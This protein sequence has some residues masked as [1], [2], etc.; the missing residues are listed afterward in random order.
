MKYIFL[1]LLLISTTTINIGQSLKDGK[2]LLNENGDHYLKLSFVS[3]FWLRSGKY[4]PGSTVFG[5]AK[6]RGTDIGIRRFRLQL[7]GQLTDKIFFFSQFGENNYNNISD[8]K[9]SFFVHDVYSE[10]AFD[11]T[12]LSVGVGLSGWSGLARFASP[13][14]GSIMGLD[15]PLFQQ[16]TNDVTDQFLRKLGVFAKGKLGRL[17]YRILVAQPL[18]FQKSPNY[19]AEV[20]KN[21]NFSSKPPKAQW[22]G[23]F[24]YQFKDIEANTTP[25]M[26]GTYHGKK[27][28]FNIGAGI[29]FQKNSMWHLSD[30][31]KDTIQT[32]LL[33]YAVD[34]F[35][36]VPI[37]IKGEALSIYANA[38]HLDYGP[39]YIRN[40]GV[41]NP[42]NGS[43]NTNVINGGGLAFPAYGTGN[44]LYF[45]IGY[46]CKDNLIGKSTLM[47]YFSLENASYAR[48]SKDMRYFST[49]VNVLLNGHKSK[50]TIAYENRPIFLDNSN[51]VVRIGNAA[52]QYQ[53]SF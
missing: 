35:Y 40:L 51:N 37:G 31:G 11:K 49:G 25:Y 33:M 15:A 21:S 14:V 10:Y 27:S 45:Q 32:N 30:S 19:S 42:T 24:Q 2:L 5:Y 29:E 23:Y 18:A 47:P 26:T 8:R 48:L 13:A 39:S 17:D 38:S 53:I 12:K 3:Q 4:N 44:V 9:P 46:K 7:F 28:V 43:T 22:N 52:L 34:L 16:A 20:T 41:M 50:V 6:E 36:D 1:W